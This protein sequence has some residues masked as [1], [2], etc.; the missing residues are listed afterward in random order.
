MKEKQGDR[1]LVLLEEAAD[2]D[3]SPEEAEAE[4][5][6]EGVDVPAFLE[7]IKRLGPEPVSIG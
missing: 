7:R 3:L 6:S 2:F 1:L 4:L 5:I